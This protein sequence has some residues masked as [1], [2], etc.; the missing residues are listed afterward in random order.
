MLNIF[1]MI[2]MHPRKTKN[3]LQKRKLSLLNSS[4]VYHR[5]HMNL[6]KNIVEQSIWTVIHQ[7]II[8]V[9]INFS[10]MFVVQERPKTLKL[11]LLK[12]LNANN[13]AEGFRLIWKTPLMS[14]SLLN[15]LLKIMRKR[16]THFVTPN[17][18]SK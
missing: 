11:M 12:F 6:M 13:N 17:Q 1:K 16:F 18:K 9:L 4:N 10:V 2:L 14:N 15:V 3:K 7:P 8:C 5:S